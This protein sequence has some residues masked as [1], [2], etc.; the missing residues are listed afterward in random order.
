MNRRRFLRSGMVAMGAGALAPSAVAGAGRWAET[1]WKDIPVGRARGAAGEIRLSANENALGISPAARQAIIDGIGSANRYPFAAKMSLGRTLAERHGVEPESVL[2]TNGSTEMIQVVVQALRTPDLRVVVADPTFEDI[3]E[4]AEPQASEVVKVPLLPDRAH[5]LDAM[6]RVASEGSAPI[7]AYVCN[8]NNPTGTLTPSAD[9]DR[10]IASAPENVFFLIDEAYF[11]FVESD[12]YH[13]A[14]S[15]IHENPRVVLARTFSK[16]HGMAGMR[17]GYGVA[18]P[19]FMA[20]LRPWAPTTNTN[21]L[22]LVAAA[23]SLD[24]P[25]H[26]RRSLDANT[27]A[28][29][30]LTDTL[31]EL[32]LAHLPSH[33]N[34][35]MHEIKGDLTLYRNRMRESGFLVGRPFP[36][37]TEHNRLSLGLPEEMTAFVETLRGFRD[38]GWV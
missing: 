23:A 20:Q 38:R 4:F 18:H 16:V 22:A 33:T 35:V 37:F 36:P 15:W 30:I 3:L 12:G 9:V 5:D 26:V 10:W 34:F 25:D 32:G 17:L 27:E 2:L 8:P 31:D 1:G 24:D 29:T 6:E 13:S 19:D 11:E 7:L 28:K 14:L 21:Q